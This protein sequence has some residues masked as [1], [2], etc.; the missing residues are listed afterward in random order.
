MNKIEI[1]HTVKR[2]D[3]APIFG[4]WVAHGRVEAIAEFPQSC[5]IGRGKSAAVGKV[6][7][8]VVEDVH[9]YVGPL[10]APR[11]AWVAVSRLI[12]LGA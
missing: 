8:A 12:V 9:Y 4:K 7:A 1:G 5:E 10:R 2:K 3:G 6:V 11:R